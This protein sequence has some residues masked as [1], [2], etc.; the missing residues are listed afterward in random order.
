VISD[1][2][3]FNVSEDLLDVVRQPD[4]FGAINP[5]GLRSPTGDT[6]ITDSKY[7]VIFGCVARD[8]ELSDEMLIDASFARAHNV[9]TSTL[10]KDIDGTLAFLGSLKGA[11]QQDF[12]DFREQAIERCLEAGYRTLA[13]V[14][15]GC[16]IDGGV[17][18]HCFHAKPLED[19]AFDVRERFL[20][21][22]P[23]VTPEE[24][25]PAGAVEAED[26]D[27]IAIRIS[28][29][30]PTTF[31]RRMV[32]MIMSSLVLPEEVGGTIDSY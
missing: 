25:H 2:E 28:L 16:A 24:E 3:R 22:W 11:A 32:G 27:N 19:V 6:P 20:E 1:Y 17:K 26:D 23:V 8:G 15:I 30:Q 29:R 13:G 9:P 31:T 7:V 4:D 14:K 10:V 18:V 5:L 12:G 21:R